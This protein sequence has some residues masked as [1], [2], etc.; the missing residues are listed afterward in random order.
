MFYILC[1]INNNIHL[2]GYLRYISICTCTYTYTCA[3]PYHIKIGLNIGSV[4]IYAYA[5]VSSAWIAT[6]SDSNG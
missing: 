2:T 4:S 1:G 5:W 6:K 3:F